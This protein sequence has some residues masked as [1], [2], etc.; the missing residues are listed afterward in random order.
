MSS[1]IVLIGGGEHAR[2]VADTL[3]AAGR[4]GDVLGFLD[5]VEISEMTE[6]TGLPFL[7]RDEEF[8]W[9]GC[10]GILGFGGMRSGPAR[11]AAVRRFAQR[12]GGWATAIHPKSAVSGKAAIGEG[13]VVFAG[14]VLNS[15]AQVGAHAVVNTGAI[16]EHDVLLGAHAQVSPRAVLGG[17]VRVGA[18]VFI[19][20]GAIIR[21][22]LSIGDGAVIGM[23]AV[24]TKDVPA[25]VLAVGHPARHRSLEG[26]L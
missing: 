6:R 25:G 15:G 17:G 3:L 16:I 18:G 8:A 14:A 5:V 9:E 7:G 26:L 13:S 10:Q 20:I 21:D 24:V 1:R 2:V 19:G 4:A 23:G 22:H 11:I 12:I